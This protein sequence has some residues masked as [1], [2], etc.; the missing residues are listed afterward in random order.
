MDTGASCS[1]T[2]MESET[3]WQATRRCSTATNV[4][5]AHGMAHL[6]HDAIHVH[7]YSARLAY[8][9]TGLHQPR[10]HVKFVPAVLVRENS[11]Q[12]LICSLDACVRYSTYLPIFK[13]SENLHEGPEFLDI[14][15]WEIFVGVNF[16][17]IDQNI[18]RIKFRI[19]EFRMLAAGDCVHAQLV[20]LTVMCGIW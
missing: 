7:V 11:T 3:N 4:Q 6:M 14:I 18:L 1:I 12:P 5:I 20:A 10:E 13:V 8:L 16:R 2:E 17:M 9:S 19:L 15:W